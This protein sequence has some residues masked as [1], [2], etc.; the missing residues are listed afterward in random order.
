MDGLKGFRVAFWIVLNISLR[1]WVAC[2]NHNDRFVTVSQCWSCFGLFL[3]L[4]HD[5]NVSSVAIMPNG[6]HIVSASRDKTIKMWEVATGYAPSLK[7][8]WSLDVIICMIASSL[9]LCFFSVP[10]L[11]REDLHRPQGVGPYGAAQPGWHTDRQL[12]QWPDCACVGRG[13]QRVQS[14]AAGAW[15]CGGVHLLGT[16][17]RPPHHPRC[18]RLWGKEQLG[19]EGSWVSWATFYWLHMSFFISLYLMFYTNCK[20]GTH[21]IT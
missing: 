10:Q 5:H 3:F 15:T 2:V 9:K 1:C 7:L 16:R 12:L 6:D 17:E 11:L 13:F 4:G 18:H 19:P 20:S 8:L 21:L 14:W